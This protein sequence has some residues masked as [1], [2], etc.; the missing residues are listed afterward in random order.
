MNFGHRNRVIFMPGEGASGVRP[1]RSSNNFDSVGEGVPGVKVEYLSPDDLDFENER[2]VEHSPDDLDFENDPPG[3]TPGSVPRPRPPPFSGETLIEPTR[4]HTHDFNR[5]RPP[6][7][8][9]SEP[10]MSR[11]PDTRYRYH[12][13]KHIDDNRDLYFIKLVAGAM[14]RRSFQSLIEVE[15]KVDGGPT[16]ASYM[17]VRVK[18]SYNNE[19]LYAW[20]TVI[21]KIKKMIN[22]PDS[23]WKTSES[24]HERMIENDTAVVAMARYVAFIMMTETNNF[25]PRNRTRYVLDTEQKIEGDRILDLMRALNSQFN[26][27]KPAL[28]T[29]YHV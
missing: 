14:K 27:L 1:G 11:D 4:P 15:D 17:N 13:T 2:N 28:V 21:E 16:S 5:E 20:T 25:I 6:D 9:H 12:V 24:I 3:L 23:A 7:S 26:I 29:R 22:T 18:Y 8:N 10:H 19:L